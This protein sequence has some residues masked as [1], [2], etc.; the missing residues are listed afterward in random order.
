MLHPSIRL[1]LWGAVTVYAQTLEG[2]GLAAVAAVVLAGTLLTAP[3]R[4]CALL[5]RA[6]WLLLSIAVLFAFATPG[7]ALSP[8]LGSASPTLDGIQLGCTHLA[9]L[10]IVLALLAALLHVTAPEQLVSALHGLLRP[11]DALGLP[12][13]RIAVRLMLVLRYVDAHGGRRR[14]TSWRQWLAPPSDVGCDAPLAIRVFRLR[15]ADFAVLTGLLAA[16]LW[17]LSF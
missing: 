10:A 13:D 2:I 6:R 14:P 11:M 4:L 3:A 7:E 12:R 17:T 1:I 8:A 5:R 15:F 16:G 9:R